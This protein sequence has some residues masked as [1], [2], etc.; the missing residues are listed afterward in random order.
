MIENSSRPLLVIEDS[1]DDFEVT[2]LALRKVAK[3]S[4]PIHRCVTGKEA[5]GYLQLDGGTLDGAS[6]HSETP[7]LILLDLNI[8]GLDG[9]K[10]L[11]RIRGSSVYTNTPVVVLTTSDNEKDIAYCYD[12]GA[13]T[14]IIKPVDLDLFFNAFHRLRSY[15]ETN[16]S[17]PKSNHI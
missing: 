10:L 12:N 1:D 5:L 8:P 17:Q 16:E 11:Q 4:N 7:I 9:R 6:N 15:V 2:E 3:F 13:T 14:Y